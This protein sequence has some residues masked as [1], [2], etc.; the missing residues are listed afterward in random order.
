MAKTAH[1]FT[2]VTIDYVTRAGYEREIEI[3]V[4]YETDGEDIRITKTSWLGEV[5]GADEYD[6]EEAMREAVW[7]QMPEAYA[8]WL[9]DYGDYLYEQ[10]RDRQMDREAAE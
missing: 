2:T 3:E 7:E 8:E 6:I 10:A 4:D 9:A 5:I 1:L